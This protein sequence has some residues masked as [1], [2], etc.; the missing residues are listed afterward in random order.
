MLRVLSLFALMAGIFE[1]NGDIINTRQ[2]YL[3]CASDF[4]NRVTLHFLDD[5]S[6]LKNKLKKTEETLRTCKVNENGCEK[7]SKLKKVPDCVRKE[8]NK[9][10]YASGTGYFRY[11]HMKFSDCVQERLDEANDEP[12]RGPIGTNLWNSFVYAFDQGNIKGI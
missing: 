6:K 3:E 4:R 7:L 9:I 1:A 2:I 12:L 11:L 5:P 8:G 10:K